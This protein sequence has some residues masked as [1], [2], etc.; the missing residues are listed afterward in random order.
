V[1]KR[2]EWLLKA[3]E[4]LD[5]NIEFGFIFILSNGK[6]LQSVA[7][8]PALGAENGML[9]FD[10]FKNV[11]EHVDEIIQAGFGYSILDNPYSE[12]QFDLESYVEMFSDWGW[13]GEVK[14][15]PGW[16]SRAL[17]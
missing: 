15:R 2:L 16:M 9:M 1:S 3:C 17:E 12:E 5:L 11:S 7:K 14:S 4:M 10:S 8:I 6:K 13:S